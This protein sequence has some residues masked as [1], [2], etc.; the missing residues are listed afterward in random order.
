MTSP[1]LPPSPRPRA[2][3]VLPVED[4]AERGPEVRIED[5]VDDRV[6]QA[7]EVAEPADDADDERREM[8]AVVAAE[9]A[10]ER[11]DEEREP[12]DDERAGDDGQ[13]A[14]SL[15]LAFLLQTLLRTLLLGTNKLPR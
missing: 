8:E 10:D 14:C 11:H 7:V 12:A 9:R 5:G 6:E 1:P 4:L 3:P 2:P 15:A 13:R